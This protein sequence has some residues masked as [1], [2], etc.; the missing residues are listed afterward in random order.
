MIPKLSQ[1]LT[2]AIRTLEGLLVVAANITLV[3]VPIVTTSLTAAQATKYGVILNVGFVFSRSLLKGIAVFGTQ[4]GITQPVSPVA[5]AAIN[6]DAAGVAGEAVLLESAV[7]AGPQGSEAAPPV[8]PP[9]TAVS[10]P[11]QPT[12]LA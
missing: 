11:A 2:K 7:K 5:L 6:K 10:P 12:N 9:V 4:T 1:P 3:V 8:Q